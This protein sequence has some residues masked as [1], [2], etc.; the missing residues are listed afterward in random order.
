MPACVDFR[1]WSLS[2]RGNSVVVE[3]PGPGTSGPDVLVGTARADTI[4]GY[5]GAGRI[6]GKAAPDR[7]YGGHDVRKDL[8]YGG[9]GNDRIYVGV[10]TV[11]SPGAG[12][13]SSG[14]PAA[15]R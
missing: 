6:Y 9:P 7:L 2:A 11:C 4:H 15:A 14:S 8:L 1:P 3:G 13:T 5:R 12:T 10:A